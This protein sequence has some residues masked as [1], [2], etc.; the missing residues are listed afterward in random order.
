M[1]QPFHLGPDEVHSWCV[2]LDGPPAKL[3]A[4]LADDERCRSARFRFERDRQ[5]FMV[6]RGAL[7]DVLGRYLGIEPGQVRF[8]YNPFGRPELSPELGS[9]L[10]FNLSHSADLALIGIAAR[11]DIGV[12]LEYVRPEP[13]YV[14]IARHF[15]SEAEVDCL[16][17]LP[18]HLQAPAFFSCW[19]KKEAYVKACG[20]GLAIPLSSFAVPLT[21]DPELTPVD[22]HGA[23][24]LYGLQP[25]PG[26]VGAL[27][28]EGSGWRLSQ[29]QWRS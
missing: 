6:A 29:W 9:R 5:R 23:W 4:T 25:A 1:I 2:P 15:F 7:R 19:T 22:L 11:A 13:D 14:E 20:D 10:K 18:S 16:N 21:T 24:S 3:S 28:I 17:S 26:Y 27:A 12:D 8:R